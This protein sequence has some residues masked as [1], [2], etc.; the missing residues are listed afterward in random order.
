MFLK[1]GLTYFIP[2]PPG[3]SGSL[4]SGIVSGGQIGVTACD[5]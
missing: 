2:Y 5:V 1:N 4:G 3:V